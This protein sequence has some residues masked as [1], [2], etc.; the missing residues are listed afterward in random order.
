MGTV[1]NTIHNVIALM[2]YLVYYIM[3]IH[4]LWFKL[5]ISV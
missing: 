2:T 5:G 1:N 3:F 4:V